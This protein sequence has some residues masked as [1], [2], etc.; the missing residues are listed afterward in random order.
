MSIS[1]QTTRMLLYPANHHWAP[2]RSEDVS[3][4]LQDINFIT[5]GDNDNIKAGHAFNRLISFLGCAPSRHTME[6]CHIDYEQSGV[7]AD[8]ITGHNSTDPRCPRCRWAQQDWRDHLDN[9]R[10][11]H[12]DT[13]WQCPVCHHTTTVRQLDW[14]RGA[15][16]ARFAINIW[17]IFPA[18]AVPSEQLLAALAGLSHCPWRYAYLRSAELTPL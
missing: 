18:E 11:V 10:S 17:N 2:E 14:R 1:E 3:R 15:V 16:I 6:A 7:E 4:V 5:S 12:G 9:W 13:P 8:I